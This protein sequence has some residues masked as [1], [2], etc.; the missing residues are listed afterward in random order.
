MRVSAAPAALLLAGGLALSGCSLA[1]S[2]DSAPT[3]TAAP[4]ASADEGLRSTAWTVAARDRVATG[5]TLRLGADAMP[6]NFNPAHPEAANSDAGRLLAPTV[7]GA[8][9]ITT[10]GGWEVDPDY[11]TSVEI[12]DKDPLTIKVRLN[13]DAVWQGGTSI[14]AADMIAYWKALNGS[15]QDFEVAS[16]AGFEDISSV[17]QGKTKFDYTVTFSQRNAEW[18]RYIYPRLAANVTSSPKV[19]NKGFR[20]RAISSNGPFVVSA[21]DSKMGTITQ[22]PNPRWWGTKPK[23]GKIV[24]QVADP[25]LQAKAYAAGDLD[26][27]DLN[28]DTYAAAS[29]AKGGVVQRAAGVDWSQVTLNGGRGPLQDAD[30]RRAVGHAIDRDAIAKAA[31]AEFG[32]S[33]EPLGSVIL[34]PGQLGY[35]DSSGK[36]AYDPKK[37]ADLLTKA[38]WV[39]EPDGARKR[40][41]KSLTLTMPVPAQT[42][43][44]SDRAKRI[45]ADLGKVGIEVKLET[46]PAE[47]FFDRRIIPLDFDL[48]TFVRQASPFPVGPA[49]AQ[50]Y[51]VDSTQNFTGI[52]RDEI[53]KGWDVTIKTLDEQLRFT[54]ITKLD[55]RL[56]EDPTVLP[57]AVTPIAVGVREGLVNYGAAQ[58][59]QPDWTL[60]G[61]LAKK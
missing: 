45:V 53:G 28:A 33:A 21:I 7:G 32:A 34:V 17:K 19:F 56:A 10:H 43:R 44:N 59:E 30:V 23:L 9:R 15:N 50:F 38:G 3:P 26:A 2:D 58:F 29:E 20:D 22:E 37:A 41:G 12:A 61:F 4:S 60:V 18:P 54:R 47:K 46:V 51:P 25:A 16:T 8:V 24:W 5:G 1:S 13:P 57:L 40:K 42:P 27:A 52:G 11:A 31:A 14:T 35:V 36:L 55:K 48:V 49:K 6:R 39:E